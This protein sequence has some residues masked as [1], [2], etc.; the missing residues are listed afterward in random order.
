MTKKSKQPNEFRSALAKSIALHAS[1]L[2]VLVIMALLGLR[3][4]G[5]GSGGGKDDMADQGGQEMPTIEVEIVEKP[6]E[7]EPEPVPM[8]GP[9]PEMTLAERVPHIDEPCQYWF[10]G[11]G[12]TFNGYDNMV[13]QVF[14]GY[15][16]ARAGIMAG[17]ILLVSKPT[18]LLGDPGTQVQVPVMRNGQ[19]INYAMYRDKICTDRPV[20]ER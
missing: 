7:E 1:P 3:G 13:Q 20:D 16:A 9:T 4:C 8:E 6:Q 5:S 17:D 18:D 12:I 11:I 2:V 10:G 19:V 14:A 15:P